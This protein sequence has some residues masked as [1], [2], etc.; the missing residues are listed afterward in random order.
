MGSTQS[1]CY[2]VN[3]TISSL[4]VFFDGAVT[5]CP[6]VILTVTGSTQLSGTAQINMGNCSEIA[7][8]GSF[9]CSSNNAFV[10]TGD[11][12]CSALITIH[13]AS[14]LCAS[15]TA[16]SQI[17]FCN[18]NNSPITGSSD[19]ATVGCGLSLPI[20]LVDFTVSPNKKGMIVAKWETMTEMNNDYFTL[21]R[22]LD[23]G[24]WRFVAEVKGA[25]TTNK[26][27][28]YSAVDQNPLFGKS[29]YRLKQTDF[30][31]EFTYSQIKS[32]TIDPNNDSKVSIY[33]NPAAD[34]ITIQGGQNELVN[35]K[36]F[37]AIGH[38]MT[39]IQS[40]LNKDGTQIKMDVSSLNSGIYLIKTASTVLRFKK[41]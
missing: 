17:Q 13:S 38:E 35:V 41:R 3:T 27:S 7:M 4:Q 34:L 28:G 26:T 37:D 2:D 29:Y 21:E 30:N 22:S 11:N 20:T 40:A 32:L 16:S 18:L 19:S 8:I 36:V 15:L 39:C 31:G 33:P 23:G 9:T 10:S 24:D 25:G 14:N 12:S 5:I 1:I 6:G